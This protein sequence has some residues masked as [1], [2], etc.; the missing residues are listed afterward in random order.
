MGERYNMTEKREYDVTH[1]KLRGR[2]EILHLLSFAMQ[3]TRIDIGTM[4]TIKDKIKM[5]W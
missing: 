4:H 2:R 1:S 5:A 3:G